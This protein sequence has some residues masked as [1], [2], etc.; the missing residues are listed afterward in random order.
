MDQFQQTGLSEPIDL[1]A[2]T[3]VSRDAARRLLSGFR[4]MGWVD[5]AGIPSE[6]LRALVRAKN[7]PEWQ[8]TLR[9]VLRKAYSFVPD[10]WEQLTADQLSAAFRKHAGRDADALNGA[11][12]F[13]IAAAADAGFRLASKLGGRASRARSDNSANF[14]FRE[15]TSRSDTEDKQTNRSKR[16]NGAANPNAS[17]DVATQ[18]LNLVALF[19]DASMTEK[20]KSAVLTLLAYL[21]R[22]QTKGDHP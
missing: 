16:T 15:A 19:D 18:V 5:E 3:V 4:A 2:V 1:D 7:T 21:K 11:Q 12:T 13:F 10:D 8:S 20:E 17:D 6:D 22:R 14:K 9:M